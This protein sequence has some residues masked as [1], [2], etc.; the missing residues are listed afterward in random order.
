MTNPAQDPL[1]PELRRAEQDIDS[2]Y[3]T[4][5]LLKETFGEAAWYFLSYCETVFLEIFSADPTD[6]FDLTAVGDNLIVHSKWPLLWLRKNCTPFGYKARPLDSSLFKSAKDLSGI[7][8][9]YMAFEVAFSEASKNVAELSIDGTGIQFSR[10]SKAFVFDA[11]DRLKVSNQD[12][13]KLDDSN[14][15]SLAV[16]MGQLQKSVQVKGDGFSYKLNPKLVR[17]GLDS[18]TLSSRLRGLEDDWLL[19]D[20]STAEF[21][22]VNRTLVVLAF[23]HLFARIHASSM[24]GTDVGL[25]CGLLLMTKEELVQRLCRYTRVP[26]PRVR[27]IVGLLTY[28]TQGQ[29]YPDPALQ[30]II[31]L[32]EETICIAPYLMVCNS[33]ERNF[34]VL[35]NRIPERRSSYSKQNQSSEKRTRQRLMKGLGD[36]F[37]YWSGNVPNWGDASEV[38]L[39]V[40][41]DEEH[42]CLCLELKSFIGPAE[43]REVFE[44]SLEI[45]KG[46]EQ[47]ETRRSKTD[48][49]LLNVLSIDAS[50]SLTWAVASET[51]IGAAWAQ[52][53][54]VPVVNANHLIEK[55]NQIQ[56][57]KD[58]CDWLEAREYLPVENIHYTLIP[59]EAKLGRWTAQ[60]Q[61]HRASGFRFLESYFVALFGSPI[62]GT[63]RLIVMEALASWSLIRQ[64][65][66]K[67]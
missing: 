51:A 13:N 60:G 11:Y 12:H 55:I 37:R 31:Q 1:S 44:R 4:N 56:S 15:N 36:Q 41:S 63:K 65:P 49:N 23:A 5:S 25:T 19:D 10:Y 48:A 22:I 17:A 66:T 64:T 43:P 58:C 9:D 33:L 53:P 46:V 39:V 47:I 28:G 18:P 2:H 32:S 21:R 42:H 45:K 14:D 7:S 40:I 57:L 50:Y 29:D 59:F 67:Q 52:S 35:L 62:H 34:L 3:L 30:P 20:F 27:T 24:A 26:E 8:M 61:K 54:T 16:F 6:P 38:D